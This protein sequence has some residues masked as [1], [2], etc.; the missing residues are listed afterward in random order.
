LSMCSVL[1]NSNSVESIMTGIT[2]GSAGVIIVE[3]KHCENG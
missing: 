3:M 2:S 1:Q